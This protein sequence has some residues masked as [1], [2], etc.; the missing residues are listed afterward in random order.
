MLM[1]NEYLTEYCYIIIKKEVLKIHSI[2]IFLS[3]QVLCMYIRVSKD[4][5]PF[6]KKYFLL[7]VFIYNRVK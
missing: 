3:A 6:F 2:F 1:F 7:I 4:Q 5:D